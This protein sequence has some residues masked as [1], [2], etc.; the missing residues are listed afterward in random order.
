MVRE[1]GIIVDREKL[2]KIFARYN[3]DDYQWIKASQIEVAHWVRFKCTFGCSSYGKKGACPPQV[4][5]VEECRAFF[6]E[7]REAVIFHIV[8]KVDK[9]EDRIPW[10]RKVNKELVKMEGEIF[11]SGYYKA[12]MMGMDECRF[13]EKCTGE[14]ELC[15]NKEDARPGP[16][17]LAVDLFN[18]V[19]SIGYPLEV[20][21]SYDQE[22]NRYAIL[23]LE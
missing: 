5:S 1:V 12:F 6:A 20:L 13:C 16:E 19:R 8:K 7:Y 15:V 22:M 21:H 4:P 17:S 10:S 2:E 18:T 9:P 14:R 11:R 23:L 3:F